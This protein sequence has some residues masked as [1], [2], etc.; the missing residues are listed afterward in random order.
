MGTFGVQWDPHPRWNARRACVSTPAWRLGGHAASSTTRRRAPR[1][2]P[3]A[4]L[5]IRDE[6]A[7][8]EYK[9]PPRSPAGLAYRV[10]RGSLE[11]DA[12]WHDGTSTL[13]HL[14]HGR[15]R[16]PDRGPGRPARGSQRRRLSPRP[17][18]EARSVVNVALGG[19]L[20][21][22][23][24]WLLHAGV[25]TDRSPVAG[26]GDAFF[27]KIDFAGAT[28]GATLS[29]D[30]LSGS[31]GIGYTSGASEEVPILHAARRRDRDR[32]SSR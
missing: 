20:R 8:F 26:G 18:Y 4:T 31:L 17:V 28:L 16:H 32:D 11:V 14:H 24:A 1:R 30:H 2:P 19:T 23:P 5:A 27:P 22:S 10:D 6:Q 3:N 12:R 25:F 15:G 29:G 13:R 21:C 7:R 9:L